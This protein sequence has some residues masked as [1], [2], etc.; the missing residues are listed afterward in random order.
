MDFITIILACI[1]TVLSIYNFREA[2]RDKKLNE[3]R[4][5]F[6]ENIN[7]KYFECF[8]D[9]ECSASEHVNLNNTY[10][11]AYNIVRFYQKGN[12]FKNSDLNF[13]LECI[14]AWALKLENSKDNWHNLIF[15]EHPKASASIQQDY[16]E[17]MVI[18]KGLKNDY[19]I[20]HRLLFDYI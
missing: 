20:F 6:F 17:K 11:L 8:D 14:Y 18:F 3:N 4:V 2:K 16:E 10:K 7:F 9:K 12:R 19:S 5:I 1:G 13:Q 15:E